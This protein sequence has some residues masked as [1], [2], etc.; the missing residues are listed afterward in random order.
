M[1]KFN[2]LL[3]LLS[4]FFP[5]LVLFGMS[6]GVLLTEYSDQVSGF[7]LL[8]VL[9]GLGTVGGKMGLDLILFGQSRE[10]LN[11][12]F[13]ISFL[14]KVKIFGLSVFFYSV[15]YFFLVGDLNKIALMLA[16]ACGLDSLSI[17]LISSLSGKR[18]YVRVFLCTVSSYFVL[19]VG[20]IYL[21]LTQN[22]VNIGILA[23]FFLVGNVVKSIITYF[24]ISNYRKFKP[25]KFV[26]GMLSGYT[27]LQQVLNFVVFKSDQLIASRSVGNWIDDSLNSFVFLSKTTEIYMGVSLAL[28]PLIYDKVKII[29]NQQIL[30]LKWIAFLWPLVFLASWTLVTYLQKSIN[31]F[32]LIIYSLAVPIGVLLNNMLIQELNRK[33]Y[34]GIFKSQFLAIC[35]VIAATFGML[36]SSALLIYY[37][38]PFT[39]VVSY[40]VLKRNRI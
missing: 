29:N 33:N 31:T 21:E 23:T 18:E 24:I 6:S 40:V 34:R 22:E 38:L 7:I 37:L 9:H 2:S 13:L 14:D 1:N 27:I 28:G 32:H 39:M 12:I 35:F 26:L 3:L 36:N 19:F 25:E 15:L 10:S 11:A 20:V 5:A 17:V 30:V 8:L 4:G 16:L